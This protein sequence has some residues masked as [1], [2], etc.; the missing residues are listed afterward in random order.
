[1]KFVQEAMGDGGPC[2]ITELLRVYSN[3]TYTKFIN[4]KNFAEKPGNSNDV[5]SK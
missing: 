3:F 4:S 2:R 5:N 1:M